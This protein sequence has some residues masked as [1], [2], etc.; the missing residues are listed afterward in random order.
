[1]K[2][3]VLN[4]HA[5][6]FEPFSYPDG[7]EF[8]N[9]KSDKSY[10]FIILQN[11][12]TEIKTEKNHILANVDDIVAK[13]VIY[14]SNGIEFDIDN[15][16]H[17]DLPLYGKHQLLDCLAVI[18]LCIRENIPYEEVLTNLKPTIA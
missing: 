1:M 18:T 17:F 6:H 15:Y 10:K 16:G 9:L 2:D 5:F 4:K 14:K 3:I 8:E 12:T 13:N 11:G 7:A